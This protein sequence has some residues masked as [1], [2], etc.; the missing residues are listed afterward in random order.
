MLIAG[1]EIAVPAVVDGFRSGA[2]GI[3]HRAVLVNFVARMRVDALL[4]LAAA[5]GADEL[6]HAA[7]GLAHSLAELATTRAHMLEELA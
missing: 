4:P 5:L 1:A 7:A 6:P 2:F 3:A